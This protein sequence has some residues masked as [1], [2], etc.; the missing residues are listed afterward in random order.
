MRFG[1][2]R[3]SSHSSWPGSLLTCSPRTHCSVCSSHSDSQPQMS[4]VSTASHTHRSNTKFKFWFSV[5]MWD[6]QN[7][8]VFYER[9]FH[10]FIRPKQDKNAYYVPAKKLSTEFEISN[11]CNKIY[12]TFN[13]HMF[14]ENIVWHFTQCYIMYVQ[15]YMLRSFVM[16]GKGTAYRYLY[17]WWLH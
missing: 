3:Q 10:R 8:A 6:L 12:V 7:I 4:L 14:W 2:A 5:R 11:C 16:V 17:W 13:V 1:K 9:I 15:W